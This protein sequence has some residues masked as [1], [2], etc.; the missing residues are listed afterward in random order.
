MNFD[1]KCL[2]GRFQPSQFVCIHVVG[3]VK[4]DAQEKMFVPT[5]F[6]GFM[7]LFRFSIM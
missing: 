5:T 2:L 7:R 6:S 1:W 4:L 3:D